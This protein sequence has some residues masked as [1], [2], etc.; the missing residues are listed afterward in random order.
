[1]SFYNTEKI[2]C[3]CVECMHYDFSNSSCHGVKIDD[4]RAERECTWFKVK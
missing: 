1:M 2:K 4:P 3:K